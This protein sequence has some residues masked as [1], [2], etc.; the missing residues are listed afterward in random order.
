MSQ[1][2]LY[3]FYLNSMLSTKVSLQQTPKA[4][5]ENPLSFTVMG[6]VLKFWT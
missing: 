4:H 6:K 2:R 5:P 1:L 3:S